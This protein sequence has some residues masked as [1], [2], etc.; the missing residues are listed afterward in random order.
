[1]LRRCIKRLCFSKFNDTPQIH[2]RDSIT[3]VPHHG[4]IMAD[5]D[6]CQAEFLP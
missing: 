5:K 4:K 1:M 3:D 6:G 2:H